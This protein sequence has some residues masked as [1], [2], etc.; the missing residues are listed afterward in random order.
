MTA[1]RRWELFGGRWQVLRRTER[2]VTV[3][4]LTCDG[5]Q[6]MSHVTATNDEFDAFLGER[7]G[8]ERR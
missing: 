3:Q 7:K 4:L 6:E 8:S 2:D 5:G 1:L